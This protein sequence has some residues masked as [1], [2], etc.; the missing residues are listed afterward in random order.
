MKRTVCALLL[1]AILI[2][3]GIDLPRKADEIQLARV[4]Y[5]VGGDKS[6]EELMIWGSKVMNQIE[7]ERYRFTFCEA[8]TQM[9]VF[10]CSLLYDERSLKAAH[11]LMMGQRMYPKE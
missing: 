10:S 1:I 5:A 8:T 4:L 7:S 9:G 2:F 6:E 11:A 3:P